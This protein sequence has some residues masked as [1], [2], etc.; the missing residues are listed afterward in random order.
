MPW[1]PKESAVPEGDDSAK[2]LPFDIAYN[3]PLQELVSAGSIC[4]HAAGSILP[5]ERLL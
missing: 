1:V 4:L 5:F 2:D 3:T